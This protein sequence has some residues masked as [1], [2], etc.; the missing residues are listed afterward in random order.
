MFDS[1]RDEVMDKLM[2]QPNEKY[3]RV[4]RPLWFFI[5]VLEVGFAKFS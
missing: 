2:G 3:I 1:A 5:E 4:C